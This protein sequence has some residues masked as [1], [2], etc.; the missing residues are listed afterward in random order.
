MGNRKSR[1]SRHNERTTA[2]RVFL[3]SD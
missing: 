2:R 1:I 3:E